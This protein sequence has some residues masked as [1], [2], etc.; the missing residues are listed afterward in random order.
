[1]YALK[2]LE[3]SKELQRQPVFKFLRSFNSRNQGRG[4]FVARNFF[5]IIPAKFIVIE[6]NV[7]LMSEIEVKIEA[8]KS[9]ANTAVT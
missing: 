1:M 3:L 8:S 7:Q 9:K 6:I 2:L 5:I 4:D